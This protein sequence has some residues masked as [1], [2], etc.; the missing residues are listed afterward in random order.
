MILSE[1]PM[2]LSENEKKELFRMLGR[3]DRGVYGDPENKQKGLID[4]VGRIEA[5]V[6]K[7]QKYA[8]IVFG[9]IVGAV[10]G[11]SEA[12]QYLIKKII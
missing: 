1:L 6:K 3:L 4:R 8:W 2:N 5:I 12:I 11:I 10:Y 7:V 9:I